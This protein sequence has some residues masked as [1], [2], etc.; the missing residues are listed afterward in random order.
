MLYCAVEGGREG[1]R[2]EGRR[3]NSPGFFFLSFFSFCR[4]RSISE[5]HKLGS[6]FFFTLEGFSL[7][8]FFVFTTLLIFKFGF[9]GG[10][11]GGRETSVRIWRWCRDV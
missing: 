2:K 1:G 10:R 11:E 7:F 5:Y 6:F 4:E 3:R 8:L 9:R